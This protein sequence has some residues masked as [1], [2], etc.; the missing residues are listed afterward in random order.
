VVNNKSVEY[1]VGGSSGG[2][3]VHWYILLIPPEGRLKTL[4]FTE[5]ISF[6]WTF[7]SIKL[8]M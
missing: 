7:S 4:N 3:N 5:V 1:E 8:A 6:L 2:L